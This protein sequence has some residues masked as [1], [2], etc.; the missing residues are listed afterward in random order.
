MGQREDDSVL[1]MRTRRG[2]REAFALLYDR[3]SRLVYSVALRVVRN[4][5]TAEDI[6]HDVF[7]Q[8]WQSPER[9]DSSRGNLP[10]WMA[11]IT[12]NRAIDRIRQ[13]RGSVDPEEVVLYSSCD[14]GS[15]VERTTVIERIRELLRTMPEPQ[16]RAVEMAFFEGKTHAEIASEMKEPLGTV[17]TRIRS[18]LIAIRKVLQP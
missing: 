5:S 16:C 14:L 12:R 15:E 8:L 7:L 9:F 6:L 17:K 10:A 3:Y 4:P 18:A 11:V 13:Q 2:E 1:V